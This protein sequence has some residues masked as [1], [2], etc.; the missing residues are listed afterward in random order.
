M[1][2]ETL[3]N[4]F[5]QLMGLILQGFSIPQLPTWVTT[6]LDDL[7]SYLLG[8]YAILGCFVN[9][10]HLKLFLPVVIVLANLERTW[11]LIMFIL[12]KIPFVGI[13]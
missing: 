8:G 9:L 7:K 3:L 4:G 11:S 12:R 2:L 13:E 1:I 10:N 5:Y 6:T